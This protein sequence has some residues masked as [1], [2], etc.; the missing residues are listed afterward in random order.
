MRYA[1]NLSLLLIDRRIQVQF[2]E[3]INPFRKNIHI[4]RLLKQYDNKR[5]FIVFSYKVGIGKINGYVPI[6]KRRD[7]KIDLCV[8]LYVCVNEFYV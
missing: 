1:E 4:Q 8:L 3:I 5:T 2:V 6:Y 7:S